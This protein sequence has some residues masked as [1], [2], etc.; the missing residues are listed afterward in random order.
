MDAPMKRI[1]M[2]GALALGTVMVASFAIKS[3]YQARLQGKELPVLGMIDNFSFTDENGEILGAQE[4]RGS[5]WCG[6]FFF[7]T[8]TGVCIPMTQSAAKLQKELRD[9]PNAHIVGISCDPDTDTPEVLRKY[10]ASFG[11]S[12]QQV[13]FARGKFDDIQSFAQGTLSLGMDK[14]TQEQLKAGAEKIMHSSRF[15]LVDELLRLRGYYDGTDEKAVQR[16]ARDMRRLARDRQKRM[17][18]K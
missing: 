8:C 5:I 17:G 12:P 7:T 2:I 11:L 3:V 6:Y 14:A 1:L 4:L 18:D 9:L 15:F 13:E 16:L 10:G